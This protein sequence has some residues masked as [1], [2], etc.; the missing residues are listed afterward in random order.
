MNEVEEVKARLDIAEVI[1]SY[2][3]LTKAGRTFKAPCPFHQEKTPSF[4][5]D[6]EPPE[7][8]LFRRL[9]HRRRRHLLRDEARR[10]RISPKPCARS[11]NAPASSSRS[12]LTAR[13][14][15]DRA[16]ARI[17]SA[18][19]AAEAYFPPLLATDAGTSPPA[20]SKSAASTP[21]LSASSASVT[22]S[23]PGRTPAST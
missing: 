12:A 13:P 8:A 4:V 3:P 21:P 20:I 17:Y 7:L 2:L 1:G 15:Q 19:E 5:V 9:W 14:E 10:H 22:A 18:N 6:P 11:P 23:A 16:R